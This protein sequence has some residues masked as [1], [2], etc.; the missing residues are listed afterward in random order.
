MYIANLLSPIRFPHLFKNVPISNIILEKW[1][2]KKMSKELHRD[3]YLSILS[4]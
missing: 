4:L 2:N 3:L 1:I